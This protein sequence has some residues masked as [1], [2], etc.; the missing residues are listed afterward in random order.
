[1]KNLSV[2][3]R[4]WRLKLLILTS[5]IKQINDLM[6]IYRIIFEKKKKS[7]N[8]FQSQTFQIY[9]AEASSF[10]DKFN[11]SSLNCNAVHD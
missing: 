7:L 3:S 4:R 10:R 2:Q 5:I 9:P 11:F 8:W 6:K 1:M